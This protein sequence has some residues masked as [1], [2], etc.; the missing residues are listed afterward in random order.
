VDDYT[1]ILSHEMAECMSSP[2]GDGVTVKPGVGYVGPEDT[3]GQVGDYEPNRY[4]VRM[5]DGVLVQPYWSMTDSGFIVPDGTPLGQFYIEPIYDA[6]HSGPHQGFTRQY[7]V[8][9]MGDA[10][11]PRDDQFAVGTFNTAF[12]TGVSVT[13]NGE[14]A[15]FD[16]GQVHYLIIQGGSGKNTVTLNGLPQDV[17][18]FLSSAGSNN[19]A[20]DLTV[21][22][23]GKSTVAGTVYATVDGGGLTVTDQT[24]SPSRWRATRP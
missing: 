6:Q 12:G 4:M 16:P 1:W 8:V 19:M 13:A 15:L 3:P 2:D 24:T 7:D 18:L 5:S 9:V 20:G 21:N 23:T 14:T 11:G 22:Y 17:A 10:G